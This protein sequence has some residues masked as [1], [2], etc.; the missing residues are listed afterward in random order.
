MTKFTELKAFKVIVFLILGLTSLLRANGQSLPSNQND[1]NSLQQLLV[2]MPDDSARVLTLIKLSDIY[3]NLDPDKGLTYGYEAL[4]TSKKI[5]YH[6]GILYSLSTLSFKYN[7]TGEWAKGIEIAYQGLEYLK[8]NPSPKWTASFTNLLNL[9]HE[10]Q[11]DYKKCLQSSINNLKYM[12]ANADKIIDPINVWASYQ[13]VGHMY[14]NLGM[15]DSALN[16]LDKGLEYIY[17]YEVSPQ[18]PAYIF[19]YKGQVYAEL[20]NYDSAFYYL[21]KK[22]DIMLSTNNQFA[23]QESMS[24]L[25]KVFYKISSLDSAKKYALIA[26]NQA[27][28]INNPLVVR[29]ASFIL[30]DL[31]ENTNLSLAH[32][33]LKKH[34]RIKDSLTTLD[35]TNQLYQLEKN[36]L[37]KTEIIE[38]ER[39]T[40]TARLRQN[41]LIGGLGTL[42]LFSLALGFYIRQ[43]QKSNKK[44]EIAYSDL[45]STQAQ[46]I[47]SEKMASLGELTAGIAHEIQNPLNF[48]NNFSELNNE[49]V[50]ELNDELAMGNEQLAKDNKQDV[51]LKIQSAID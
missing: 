15:P 29:D 43:K 46:L 13:S 9:G 16:Y 2:S 25:A 31:Y 28:G 35:K 30:A 4:T 21:Y 37:L 50:T 5:N 27:S 33:Y 36:E 11:G 17:Q 48:V 26:Y 40:N 42:S 47:Q 44:L 38:K 41:T 14:A 6:E 23:Y 7:I 51:L 49:L 10:K 45:Q 22:T 18:F 39:I 20:G 8:E 1:I 34:Q 24:E 32:F 12:K 3:T 19:G